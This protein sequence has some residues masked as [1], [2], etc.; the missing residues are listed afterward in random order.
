MRTVR[1]PRP[2]PV[3]LFAALFLLAALLR[4]VVSLMDPLVMLMEV[5]RVWPGLAFSRDS[6]IVLANAQFT[7][8]QI[9]SR[10]PRTWPRGSIYS[11]RWS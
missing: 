6:A 11:G 1:G 9:G 3:C 2:W 7:I 5:Y 4:L 8:A 10:A